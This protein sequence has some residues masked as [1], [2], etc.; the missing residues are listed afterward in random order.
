MCQ[1]TAGDRLMELIYA[2]SVHRLADVADHLQNKVD[3]PL[4][5]TLPEG[6]I[7][8][9]SPRRRSSTSAIR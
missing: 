6:A 1:P 3:L 9:H 7:V 5:L 8:R 4:K 2:E